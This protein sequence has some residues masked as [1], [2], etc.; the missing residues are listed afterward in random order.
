MS[1]TLSGKFRKG[2]NAMTEIDY[3]EVGR[4][5]HELERTHGPDAARRYAA[6][7]AL[8]AL[9]DGEKDQHAFWRAV[10]MSLSPR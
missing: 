8:E 3:I 7:I 2:S 6:K 1:Q 4:K 10:E 9:A 5:A